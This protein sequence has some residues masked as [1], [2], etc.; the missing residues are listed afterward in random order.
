MT[1]LGTRAA[2]MRNQFRA[3]MYVVFFV[4]LFDMSVDGAVGDAHSFGDLFVHQTFE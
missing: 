3:A 4:D 2:E 1:N